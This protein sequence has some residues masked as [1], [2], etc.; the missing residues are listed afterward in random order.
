MFDQSALLKP[1]ATPAETAAK[2]VIAD[3][4]PDLT[5]VARLMN[6]DTCPAEL[7]VYLAWALSVDV[8]DS[9]WSEETQRNVIR[10]SLAIHRRKGTIGAVQ[11]ALAAAG[12][13]DA[14]IVERYAW[15]FYDGT[16]LRDGS[17]RREAPDHWAEYRVALTR[18]IT[19]EQAA[20]VRRILANVAPARCHLRGLEYQQA[21]H[22][23]DG[24]LVRDGTFTRGTA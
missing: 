6:P 16:H 10:T 24:Q 17:I 14:Q 12:Y 3:S 22:L 11:D 5:P 8:W 2:D 4:A 21:A 13:G 9:N 15:E 23:Y 19:V 18:P 7:L 20:Q 1:N